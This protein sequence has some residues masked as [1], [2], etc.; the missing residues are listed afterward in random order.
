[1]VKKKKKLYIYTIHRMCQIGVHTF[2][3]QTNKK[4]RCTTCVHTFNM[5]W[6]WIFKELHN[7]KP[8][9]LLKLRLRMRSLVCCDSHVTTVHTSFRLISCYIYVNTMWN[10]TLYIIQTTNWIF[11]L[12]CSIIA[13]KSC[14]HKKPKYSW[15][16]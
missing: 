16:T 15:E 8:V 7:I 12:K 6:S 10:S 13:L 5:L 2:F 11:F 3:K 14:L 4:N 1:M 9:F